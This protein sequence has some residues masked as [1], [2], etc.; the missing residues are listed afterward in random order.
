MSNGANGTILEPIVS[1]GTV[2]NDDQ[3]EKLSW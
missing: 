3:R 1:G 2:S